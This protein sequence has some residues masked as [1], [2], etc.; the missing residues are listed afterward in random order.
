LAAVRLPA[1]INRQTALQAAVPAVETTRLLALL[2]VGL[3]AARA[4][5]ALLLLSG[6]LSIFVALYTALRQRE[7]DMAMLRVMGA[8][9]LA[10]FAQVISEGLLLA[11]AG[12]ILGLLLGHG[13]VALAVASFEQLREV[14]LTAWR[15]EPA[16]GSIVLATLGAGAVAALLPA[17]RVFGVDIARTLSHAR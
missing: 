7:A 14:G 15:F 12:A 3:D 5:A 1:F 6:C 11:A 4:F 16:E 9:P 2:G 8:K 17:L 13:V 10:I